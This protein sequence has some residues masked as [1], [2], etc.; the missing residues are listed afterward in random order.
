MTHVRS[1]KEFRFTPTLEIF[2]TTNFDAKALSAVMIDLADNVFPHISKDKRIEYMAN[3]FG[4]FLKILKN[5]PES[6][7]RVDSVF[8]MLNS[9]REEYDECLKCGTVIRSHYFESVI[10]NFKQYLS[11][12]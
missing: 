8:N 4:V 5:R 2:K 12:L 3:C 1:C 7:F 10:E 9:K 6:H 11:T